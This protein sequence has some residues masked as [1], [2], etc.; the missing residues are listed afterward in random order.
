MTGPMSSAPALWLAASADAG[1]G[2]SAAWPFAS[3]GLAVFEQP[4]GDSPVVPADR[5]LVGQRMAG[6]RQV[7]AEGGGSRSRGS[8]SRLLSLFLAVRLFGRGQG[9]AAL[10]AVAINRQRLQAQLP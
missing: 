4:H 7:P 2:A 10:G 8:S 1:L 3:P 6:G 5:E 9:L